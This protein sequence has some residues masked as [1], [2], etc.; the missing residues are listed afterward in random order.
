MKKQKQIKLALGHLL[1]LGVTVWLKKNRAKN[2]V[3]QSL[4]CSTP[5]LRERGTSTLTLITKIIRIYTVPGKFIQTTYNCA[6]GTGS[7][8]AHWA[9]ILIQAVK[10]M[11]ILRYLVLLHNSFNYCLPW[12][13]CL[14]CCERYATFP[15]NRSILQ[16]LVLFVRRNNTGRYHTGRYRIK[17]LGMY[18]YS[19]YGT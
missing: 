2:L 13:K 9:R 10:W 14:R 5:F 3:A 19:R 6:T 4:L 15:T 11:R 18:R 1:G 7:G 17:Y 12:K 16:I 8:S